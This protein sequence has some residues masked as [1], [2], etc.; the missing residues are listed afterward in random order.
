MRKRIKHAGKI[1]IGLQLGRAS[2]ETR[3]LSLG[4]VRFFRLALLPVLDPLFLTPKDLNYL[5]FQFFDF[6]NTWQRLFQKHILNI[7]LY[8]IID[9][10]IAFTT[11]HVVD[12]LNNTNQI[13]GRLIVIVPGVIGQVRTTFWFSF[14]LGWSSMLSICCTLWSITKYLD[15]FLYT[16]FNVDL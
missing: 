7:Y 8:I 15:G 1:S 2:L 3:N 16:N 4:C 10:H 5:A 14:F 13:I 12:F 11:R 6:E 9:N